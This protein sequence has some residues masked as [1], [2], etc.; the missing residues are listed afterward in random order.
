MSSNDYEPQTFTPLVRYFLM[1]K[2]K[3]SCHF[4]DDLMFHANE[5]FD[6]C[7]AILRKLS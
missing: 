4:A 1:K 2:Q 5:V 3:A 6:T 7:A